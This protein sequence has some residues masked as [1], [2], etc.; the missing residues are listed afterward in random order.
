MRLDRSSINCTPATAMSLAARSG[1]AMASGSS[2][3]LD[4]FDGVSHG[5]IWPAACCSYAYVTPL[6]GAVMGATVLE[7]L[8]PGAFVG[9]ALVLGAVALEL[10]GR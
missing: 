2:E 4:R 10:R 6:V 7:P 8:W 3:G 9:A 5:P 1:I